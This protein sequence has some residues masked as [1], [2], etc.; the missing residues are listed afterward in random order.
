MK[1]QNLDQYKTPADFRGKSKITV[2]L[3]WI[4]QATLFS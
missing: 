4:V 2:Q 1:Y 3:W